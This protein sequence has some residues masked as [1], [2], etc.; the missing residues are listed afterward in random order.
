MACKV[1]IYRPLHKTLPEGRDRNGYDAHYDVFAPIARHINSTPLAEAD[2]I[3]F[4]ADLTFRNSKRYAA[5]SEMSTLVNNSRRLPVVFSY[6]SK[7]SR[8]RGGSVALIP[9]SG[10]YFSEMVA[11]AQQILVPFNL[12]NFTSWLGRLAPA[13]PWATRRTALFV[14]NVPQLYVSPSRWRIW[15]Q[16]YNRSDVTVVSHN[17]WTLG[18][19]LECVRNGTWKEHCTQLLGP[20]DTSRQGAGRSRCNLKPSEHK[21]RATMREPN[22]QH[23]FIAAGRAVLSS[24]LEPAEYHRAGL[25]HK[26]C[27]VAGGDYPN[28]LKYLEAIFFA[29]HGGCVPVFADLSRRG[30]AFGDA[31]NYSRVALWSSPQS[32]G[33]D[34][35][36]WKTWSEEQVRPWLAYARQVADLLN[37]D[38]AGVEQVVRHVCTRVAG[39]I[40]MYERPRGVKTPLRWRRLLPRRPRRPLV[41][42]Q[43]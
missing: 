20:E 43:W 7:N 5:I 16:L 12:E 27:V 34:L 42:K 36:V 31:I 1:H 38:A 28:T 11:T 17:V 22:F 2:F 14:G 4:G 33:S 23:D 32:L 9:S 8:L 3:L 15:R 10:F 26:F 30:L 39:H 35:D 13:A 41:S 21:C 19:G 18:V 25:D 24:R 29:S 37:Y 40:G 6:F